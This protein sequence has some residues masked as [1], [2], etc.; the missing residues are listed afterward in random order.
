MQ[1]KE[2]TDLYGQNYTSMAVHQRVFG[3]SVVKGYFHNRQ[4][5]TDNEFKVHNYNRTAGIQFE[6]R[7]EDGR[8]RSQAG[9]GNAFTPN[10]T[11]KKYF[12]S[13]EVS[14]DGKHIS[15]YSNLAGIGDNY[16]TDVGFMPRMNHY[17][18]VRDTT[19]IIG[20]YHWFSRLAYSFYPRTETGII[21]QEVEFRNSRDRSNSGKLIRNDVSLQY[22]VSFRNTSSIG[23]DVSHEDVNLFFP[24]DFTDEDPLP[25]GG[26]SFERYSIM[27]RSDQRKF[28]HFEAGISVGSFYNGTRSEYSLQAKYRVQP[29]GNFGMRLVI[30]NLDFP[31]PFGDERL[32]LV[33]PRLEFNFSRDLFWTTF[34]QY[35][36]QSDNFNIN[37]RFQWRFQPLSDLFIV[38]TDNYAVEFWG[39]KNRALVLKLNYWLNL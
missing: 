33:G 19:L 1:T 3:R 31:A 6:Y 39:P 26:Y 14:Y 37:S 2:T 16:I 17:D 28:L 10:Q 13:A 25:A 9:F 29:W 15:A 18:A 8:W 36:T 20:F 12:Y 11:G 5:Y 34:L 24:F 27:Y 32:F 21:K 30:N 4:A 23:L 35:N 7:S 38:Y 22:N